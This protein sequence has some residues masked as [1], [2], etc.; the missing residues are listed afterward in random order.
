MV[1]TTLV[2]LAL[3]FGLAGFG[4]AVV[5]GPS[6]VAQSGGGS[7]DE[8]EAMD[9]LVLST[10][11]VVEG[12][13]LEETDTTIT[14]EVIIGSLSAET[15]YQKSEVMEI[16]RGVGGEMPA[17]GEGGGPSYDGLRGGGDDDGEAAYDTNDDTVRIY[18]AEIEGALPLRVSR[19]SFEAIFDDV[20]DTFGDI[21]EVRRGPER[22]EVV[23]EDLRDKNIVVFKLDIAT[24]PEQAFDGINTAN[25][26]APLLRDQIDQRGRRVI[27]W[28]E[29]AVAGGVF[30]PLTGPELYFDEGGQMGGIGSLDQFTTGDKLVDEKLIG[31]RLGVAE[32]YVIRAG[33]GENGVNV[34]RAMARPQYHLWV[35]RTGATPRTMLREPR[36]SDGPNWEQVSAPGRPFN[37]TAEMAFDIGL[38]RGTVGTVEDLAFQLGI[39]RN[40]VVIDENDAEEEVDRWEEEFMR[41]L[42][43]VIPSWG[44]EWWEE[45]EEIEVEGDA[46]EQRRA[47]SQKISK[48]NQI[49]SV[50]RRY[51]AYLD[52]SG[53]QQADIEV[54]LERWRQQLQALRGSF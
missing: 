5:S 33:Y 9:R 1:R 50:F 14:M 2:V 15:T 41:A 8:S 38:S 48:L 54:R 39:D 11:R 31:A 27:F 52:P 34:M 37:L 26:I 43:R 3:V 29:S 28:V 53:T 17:G 6:A 30:I 47:I 49:R 16:R 35:D 12:R 42:E 19:E 21:V 45:L 7:G 51:E 44:G 20:D 36:A 24:N 10:G 18:Y 4:P 13:I 23:R 40:Y 46:R 25:T 32:G 22:V